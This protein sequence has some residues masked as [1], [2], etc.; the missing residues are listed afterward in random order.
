M[1]SG[2][3]TPTFGGLINGGNLA[4]VINSGYNNLTA[5]TLNLG[6]G[7]TN[8]YSGTIADGHSGTTLTMIGAGTQILS[9][10]NT[11]TGATTISGGTLVVN[12]SLASSNVAVGTAATLAGT[13]VL[14]NNATVTGAGV[15]NLSGGSIG[16]TLGVTGGFW[17]GSGTVGGLVTSSSNTFTIP[18]GA[19]LTAAGGMNL[20]GGTLT[21]KGTVSGG[22]LT[23][24]SGA[25]I[26]PG[27]TAAT[28]N[29]GTLNLANLAASGGGAINFDLSANT[30]AGGTNDL[31]AV[32]GNL[33]LGGTTSVA[34]NLYQTSALSNGQ[35]PL[36]TYGG[37]LG[38]TPG[39]LALANTGILTLRQSYQF[40]T[41]TANVV[42]LD[43]NGIAGNL[44]WVGSNAASWD[45]SGGTTNWLNANSL[46]D[47]FVTGDNV[48]FTSSSSG[49]VTINAAVAPASVTVSGSYTFTGPGKITNVTALTVQS[50]AALTIAN[51]NDYTLGTNV[52]GGLLALGTN[53]ALPVTG[54]LTMGTAG[55][56]GTFDLAG[57]NQTIGALGVGSGATA[58]GQVITASTGSSTLTYSGSTA[59]VFAGAIQDTATTTGGTLGLTVTSGTLDVSGG[60]TTYAGATT[61]NSGVLRAGALP[62]TSA[63]AVNGGSLSAV[64]YNPA[65][66]MTVASGAVAS[67]SGSGLSLSAVTNSGSVAFSSNSGTISLTNFSGPGVA[68]FASNANLTV[69]T[70]GSTTIGGAANIGAITGGSTTIGGA[71]N[72]GAIAGGSMTIGG[73]ATISTASGDTINFN[74]LSASVG[75]LSSAFAQLGA[76]T[77]LTLTTEDSGSHITGAGKLAVGGGA[78]TTLGGSNTYSAGTTLAAGG[79][80]N[81]NNNSALGSGSLAINGG[82][83]D[84][85]SGGAVALGTNNAQAWNG[86]FT[87][88]GTNSLNL[89][90]GAVTMGSSRNVTV[91]AG[92]LTVGGAIS[93]TNLSLTKSGTGMLTLSAANTYSGATIISAGTISLTGLAANN[94][95]GA[96]AN[97]LENTPITINAGGTLLAGGTAAG[98]NS[99]RINGGI[100]LNG[101]TLA[102]NGVSGNYD[103]NFAIPSGGI[104]AGGGTTSLISASVGFN[105]TQTINVGAGSTLNMTGDVGNWENQAWG[106]I[107]K[108]GPGLLSLTY[109]GNGYGGLQIGAGTVNVGPGAFGNTGDGTVPLVEFT[110]SSYLQWGP[111]NTQDISASNK[112]KIDDG[113]TATLNTGGNNV[114]LATAIVLGTNK[115]G[116]LTKAGSGILTLSASEAYTAPRPSAAARWSCRATPTTTTAAT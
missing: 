50:G 86:D 73:A 77:T 44:T 31:I 35:Y 91:N 83:L 107:N 20:T 101:G 1:G 66:N 47:Q 54:T 60:S 103:Y 33:S 10:S 32:A 78:T 42:Y 70:G 104:T 36:F 90:T 3:T 49:A 79:L 112:L 76:G 102:S 21:G 56:A 69:L 115:T 85:T 12:N 25:V 2:V 98:Y 94:T 37:N 40:D 64:S 53:N 9:G 26:S 11:Y 45:N 72:I 18:S 116:T 110:G 62:N 8:S 108:T 84:N 7:V 95:T 106:I 93:G 16:G 67:I 22:T 46:P 97:E 65:A 75:T 63:V 61:L 59:S 38:Y 43:I 82:T 74:G 15:I 13:G 5:L 17:S 14:N 30:A 99:H 80:L 48:N 71:A 87:F 111:G 28:N 113:M 89:G 39:A 92:N 96:L 88:N 4:T 52:Q 34:V 19:N 41:N 27:A 51:T 58:S 23:L 55:S 24:G 68:T 81:I 6:S 109:N 57:Y 105:G 114:T 29:I 100:T